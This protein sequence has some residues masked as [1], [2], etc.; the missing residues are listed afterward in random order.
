M[1]EQ[2]WADPGVATAKK[3]E[4]RITRTVQLAA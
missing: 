2:G 3:P 1:I 4:T